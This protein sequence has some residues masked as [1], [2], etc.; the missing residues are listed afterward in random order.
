MRAMAQPDEPLVE[1]DRVPDAS[2]TNYLDSILGAA[3]SFSR[4]ASLRAAAGAEARGGV[5]WEAGATS[6]SGGGLR[7]REALWSGVS[8]IPEGT[9]SH[10]TGGERDCVGRPIGCRARARWHCPQWCCAR[11]A[12]VCLREIGCSLVSECRCS[13]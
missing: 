9:G 4:M 11:G 5:G 13:S 1:M 8:A 12:A 7:F 10:G 6:G 3:P 2:A